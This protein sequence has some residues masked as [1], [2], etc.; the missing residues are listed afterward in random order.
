MTEQKL[1]EL[2]HQEIDGVNSREE[3]RLVAKYIAEDPEAKRLF[4][5]LQALSKT[6]SGVD[7]LDAPPTLK[8]AIGRSLEHD[9]S[10]ASTRPRKLRILEALESHAPG[11][12]L[13]YAFSGGVLAGIVLFLLGGNLL[14]LGQ[15][16]QNDI[17]GTVGAG[18]VSVL[19]EPAEIVSIP[20]EDL[21]GE[22]TTE[23][24]GRLR[25]LRFEMTSVAPLDIQIA[26]DRSALTLEGVK[27]LGNP[28]GEVSQTH[29]G[30][31]IHAEGHIAFELYLTSSMYTIFH[32]VR[33]QS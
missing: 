27:R 18:E 16:N 10:S 6:L 3:S 30:V 32:H 21:Q 11:W 26:F 15:V 23:Y 14:E 20:L 2:L 8:P 13:G 22:I 31:E 28:E 29:E 19:L 12:R 33:R 5:E 9:Y 24:S 4:D 25:V 17:V 1:I 7:E